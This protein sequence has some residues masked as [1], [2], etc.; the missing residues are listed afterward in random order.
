VKTRRRVVEAKQ[1][2]ALQFLAQALAEMKIAA[3]D[4]G[5]AKHLSE[6]VV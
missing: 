1:S 6:G 5:L 3:Q 2:L 4:D